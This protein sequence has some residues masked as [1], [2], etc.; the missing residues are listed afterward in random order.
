L[1]GNN[2]FI[3]TKY[4]GIDPEINQGGLAP[5]IDA[6]NF[7]PRTRTFMFGVNVSF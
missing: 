7:Y 4:R 1:S 2:V 6:N 3:I 5:G